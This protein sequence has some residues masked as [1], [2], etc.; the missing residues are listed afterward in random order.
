VELWIC[1]DMS[2]MYRVMESDI[3]D[4][5]QDQAQTCF[6]TWK[7]I[8]AVNLPDRTRI[9]DVLPHAHNILL[10]IQI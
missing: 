5:S 1:L 9:W 4:M 3:C 10:I 6:V 2:R 8:N 7:F